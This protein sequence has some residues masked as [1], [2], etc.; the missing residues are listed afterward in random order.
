MESRQ[1]YMEQHGGR[2]TGPPLAGSIPACSTTRPLWV[3]GP[4]LLKV[5]SG[6]HGSL[7]NST[8]GGAGRSS[9]V[10]DGFGGETDKKETTAHW[11]RK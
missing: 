4:G 10:A 11:L 3:A 5:F 2:G 9:G 8:M 1:G 6:V 7:P